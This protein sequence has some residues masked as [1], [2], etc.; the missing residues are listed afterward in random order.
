MKTGTGNMD[1]LSHT[2]IL[3][4][5]TIFSNKMGNVL[6]PTS[7][8]TIIP[9]EIRKPHRR[10]SEFSV[11]CPVLFHDWG[12]QLVAIRKYGCHYPHPMGKNQT[13]ETKYSLILVQSNH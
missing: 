1:E 4:G 5:L 8:F 13:K 7:T 6:E 3:S 9:E 10:A 12:E 2:L 11:D